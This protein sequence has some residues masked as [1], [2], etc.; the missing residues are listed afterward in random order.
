MTAAAKTKQEIFFSL[1][2]GPRALVILPD[3]EKQAYK[4]KEI[5]VFL[6]TRVPCQESSVF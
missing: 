2:K 1:A 5:M 3:Y 6:V 4:E